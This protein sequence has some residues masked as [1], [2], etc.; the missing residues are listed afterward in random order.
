MVRIL[1]SRLSS[2]S[3]RSFLV[4]ESPLRSDI[5]IQVPILEP[6]ASHPT[7][8]FTITRAIP[9]VAEYAK[10]QLAAI[11]TG[12]ASQLRNVQVLLLACDGQITH[13]QAQLII[14]NMHLLKLN[15]TLQIKEKG[16][17][18][19]AH[20]QLFLGGFWHVLTNDDFIVLQEEVKAWKVTKEVQKRQKKVKKENKQVLLAEQKCQWELIHKHHE[21][22]TTAYKEECVRFKAHGVKR[23]GWP[24]A[25][26]H[27][28]KPTLDEI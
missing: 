14:Q 4:S 19:D 25:P 10:E 9:N 3:S 7:S 11:I 26:K 28:R 20:L 13:L 1:I 21:E 18:S 5:P 15:K 17:D 6:S 24:K 8:T 23:N 27:Q 12:L 22:V 2:T 16:K